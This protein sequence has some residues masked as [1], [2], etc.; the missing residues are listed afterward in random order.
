MHWNARREF[1][2]AKMMRNLWIRGPVAL[3]SPTC[4]WN[5][6]CSCH[7]INTA[8]AWGRAGFWAGW[9]MNPGDL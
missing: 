3:F 7:Q 6:V 4:Q 1:L 9:G 8:S 5:L 2:I